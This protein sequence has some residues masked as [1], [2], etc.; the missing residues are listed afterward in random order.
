[1]IIYYTASHIERQGTTQLPIIYIMQS[2]YTY[3]V[4]YLA[5]W[6]HKGICVTYLRLWY[7]GCAAIT[8][9]RRSQ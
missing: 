2:I 4:N 8:E 5:T 6:Y 7:A 3:L 9:R 1:M